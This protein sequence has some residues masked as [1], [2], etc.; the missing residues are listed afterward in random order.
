MCFAARQSTCIS[1]LAGPAAPPGLGDRPLTSALHFPFLLH[2]VQGG[3]S[4]SAVQQPACG[5]DTKVFDWLGSQGRHRSGCVTRLV[6]NLPPARLNS[7]NRCTPIAARPSPALTSGVQ[8]PLTQF[9]QGAQTSSSFSLLQAISCKHRARAPSGCVSWGGPS[10]GACLP[11]MLGSCY[12]AP[13]RARGS[14]RVR[15][16]AGPALDWS[17]IRVSSASHLAYSVSGCAGG[18][19]SNHTLLP[20]ICNVAR[21]AV[22]VPVRHAVA[23]DSIAGEAHRTVLLAGV[24]DL[25]GSGGMM[26]WD[27]V[28][29]GGAGRKIS[30]V[31]RLVYGRSKHPPGCPGQFAALEECTTTVLKGRQGTELPL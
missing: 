21:V 16:A 3:Q 12:N 20:G 15:Q 22:L 13:P 7:R 10:A 4:S 18:I 1:T 6:H 30:S 28:G 5:K 27:E 29:W 9:S 24:G 17:V 2:K 31:R 14:Q 11:G 8:M 19:E 26:G 23:G 25:R